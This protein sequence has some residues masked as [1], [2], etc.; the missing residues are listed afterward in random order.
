MKCHRVQ[1]HRTNNTLVKQQ[2]AACVTPKKIDVQ[3]KG[4]SGKG[5][6]RQRWNSNVSESKYCTCYLSVL[7]GSVIFFLK[8]KRL[9]QAFIPVTLSIPRQCKHN[10]FGIKLSATVCV[11]P[12]QWCRGNHWTPPSLG[13][14]S[15][16]HTIC[17]QPKPRNASCIFWD[18]LGGAV[19]LAPVTESPPYKTKSQKVLSSSH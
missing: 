6:K 1:E 16:L 5:D 12:G 8:I 18:P 11:P 14:S 15:L 13:C 4:Q 17:C 10:I 7:L 3:G 19:M 2:N 9:M